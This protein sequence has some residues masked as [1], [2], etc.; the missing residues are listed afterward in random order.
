MEPLIITLQGRK[1]LI[2]ASN[3]SKM[4]TSFADARK[5]MLNRCRD[6]ACLASVVVTGKATL[7]TNDF[8]IFEGKICQT[9]NSGLISVSN[10]IY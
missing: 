10:S 1:Q 2:P 6:Q 9:L 5:G 7:K 4:T 8:Y 3:N